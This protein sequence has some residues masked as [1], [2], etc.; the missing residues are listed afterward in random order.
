MKKII[1][2]LC[3]A[4]VLSSCTGHMAEVSMISTR[5]INVHDVNLDKLPA[6][7]VVGE[8]KAFVFLFIPFG[9]PD[10]ETAVNNALE[11]GQGDLIINGT[12][13][14]TCWWFVVGQVGVKVTGDVVN[15]GGS[16]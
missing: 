7:T 16:L 2:S 3:A 12:V 13:Y 10:V 11:K 15:T 1:L 5:E 4:L 14:S 9:L 6:K 8:D